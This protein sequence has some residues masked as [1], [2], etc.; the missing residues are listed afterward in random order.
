MCFT[1]S[2]SMQLLFDAQMQQLDALVAIV[3]LR[4]RS[5]TQHT[6]G[7]SNSSTCRDCIS[8]S[9]SM[10]Q[11][12]S[13]HATFKAIHCASTDQHVVH[14][15]S[16]ISLQ[17]YATTSCTVVASGL[18]CINVCRSRSQ[19][20]LCVIIPHAACHDFLLSASNSFSD[21]QLSCFQCMH[22]VNFQL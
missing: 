1:D 9:S 14:R 17:R 12:H 13:W 4:S 6:L 20:L 16:S 5:A 19:F 22:C 15:C 7:S 21:I 11:R 10:K 18:A 2:H 8:S 3:Q